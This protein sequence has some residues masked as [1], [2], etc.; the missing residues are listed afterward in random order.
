MTWYKACREILQGALL[1]MSLVE[2]RGCKAARLLCISFILSSG[3][4]M[5]IAHVGGALCAVGL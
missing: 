5:G 2:R 4:T 3:L 1:E